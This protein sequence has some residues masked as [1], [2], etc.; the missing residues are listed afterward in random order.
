MTPLAV[1][2]LFLLGFL[3]NIVHLPGRMR[4]ASVLDPTKLHKLIEEPYHFASLLLMGTTFIVAVFYLLDSLYGERRD[5]SVLFWKSLPVSDFTSVLA[6]FT[7]A[8]IVIP[9]II[10]IAVIATQFLMLV[11]SSIVLFPSGLAGTTW[12]RFNLF[13]QSVIL[14]Y[15]LAA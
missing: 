15:S 11:W 2:A 7:I 10:S 9:L 8:M 3:I 5:R 14:L 6:K 13:E 12:T 1:A 4:A